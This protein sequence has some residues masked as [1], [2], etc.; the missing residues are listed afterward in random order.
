MRPGG[1]VVALPTRTLTR[2]R[3]PPCRSWLIL[4]VGDFRLRQAVS[5]RRLVL[6][7]SRVQARLATSSTSF[8]CQLPESMERSKELEAL[9]G[10]FYSNCRAREQTAGDRRAGSVPCPPRKPRA[11]GRWNVVGHLFC[12]VSVRCQEGWSLAQGAAVCT[13]MEGSVDP[14]VCWLASDVVHARLVPVS[15]RAKLLAQED[16]QE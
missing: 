5:G 1:P 9:S 4:S 8:P 15:V 3:I 10:R 14:S 11:W 13:R 7:V 16:S 6:P 2:M 12:L